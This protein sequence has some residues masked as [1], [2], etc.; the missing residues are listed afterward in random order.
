MQLPS[1]RGRLSTWLT[2]RL[3]RRDNTPLT[4]QIDPLDRP[5]ADDDLQLALWVA[6][7]LQY[8]G[9]D[10]VSPDFQWDPDI[11]A[12][13]TRLERPWTDWLETN[14]RDSSFLVTSRRRSAGEVCVADLV[15]GLG[16]GVDL[17][18][19]VRVG[20]SKRPSRVR[21]WLNQPRGIVTAEDVPHPIDR[22]ARIAG[23]GPG[24][25]SG[26]SCDLAGELTKSGCVDASPVGNSTFA[27]T[28][29]ARRVDAVFAG[30]TGVLDGPWLEP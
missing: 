30:R 25:V 20:G 8:R 29:V 15:G 18:G 2:N 26:K 27:G 5:Y 7:E 24:G 11:I 14:C 19:Q 22:S 17:V 1:P 3:T 23:D 13:R 10:D 16:Q 9:F 21:Q 4:P 28:L 6:Y 12:F